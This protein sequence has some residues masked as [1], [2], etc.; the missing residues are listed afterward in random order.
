MLPMV[1]QHNL[2]GLY[3]DNVYN[4]FYQL[5]YCD[6]LLPTSYSIYLVRRRLNTKF[7]T[8]SKSSSLFLVLKTSFH[9][10]SI[11]TYC[12]LHSLNTKETSLCRKILKHTTYLHLH[13]VIKSKTEEKMLEF[14]AILYLYHIISINLYI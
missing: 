7:H 3:K 6:I 2:Y 4:I 8:I 12:D 11:T 10:F 13:F 1:L 9:V 5:H 14:V